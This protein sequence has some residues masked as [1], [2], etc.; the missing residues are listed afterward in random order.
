MPS[1]LACDAVELGTGA[2]ITSAF[3][4]PRHMPG[5]LAC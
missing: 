1:L 5:P 4:I 3:V 2:T